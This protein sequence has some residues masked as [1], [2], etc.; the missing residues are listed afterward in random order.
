MVE[1]SCMKNLLCQLIIPLLI[2]R[3]NF[4]IKPSLGLY[5]NTSSVVPTFMLLIAE[6][7][8][9]RKFFFF[10]QNES[11]RL[12]FL[13]LSLIPNLPKPFKITTFLHQLPTSFLILASHN[14]WQYSKN[15]VNYYTG[16]YEVFGE[17]S[18]TSHMIIYLIY[19]RY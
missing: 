1:D 8:I 15:P 19:S 13:Y 9:L 3:F 17:Q 16:I 12:L 18:I 4:I 7:A 14:I 11:L 6:K 2:R 5:Q 10:L